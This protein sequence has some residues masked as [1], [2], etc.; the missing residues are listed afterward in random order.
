M[1]HVIQRTQR[2]GVFATL[3][4]WLVAEAGRGARLFE[5]RADAVAAARRLAHIA[6]WR[7][8][9]AEVVAQDRAGGSLEV[10]DPAPPAPASE[11]GGAEP[12]CVRD[13]AH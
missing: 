6:R 1:A 12:Q 4:G 2:L 10:I 7:G 9:P 3:R 8:V 13:H 11:P 5:S